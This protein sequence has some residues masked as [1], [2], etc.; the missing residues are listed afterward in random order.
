MIKYRYPGSIITRKC[1]CH[2]CGGQ[3]VPC[4]TTSPH[5][6][7]PPP[8]KR[9]RTLASCVVVTVISVKFIVIQAAAAKCVAATFVAARRLARKFPF[10]D[11]SILSIT[12]S[13]AGNFLFPDILRP[14]KSG[15]Q[16]LP[17]FQYQFFSSNLSGPA[18]HF[19]LFHI[20]ALHSNCFLLC[21]K[22]RTSS[23]SSLSL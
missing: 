12:C 3:G 19:W 22:R 2:F 1:Y 16:P 9:A 5:G 8:I 7:I 23:V 18:D 6:L 21:L 4:H 20:C 11:T 10:P 14:A 13:I 15:R 17:A